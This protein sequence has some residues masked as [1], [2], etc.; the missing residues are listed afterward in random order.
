MSMEFQVNRALY[1]G[2]LEQGTKAG[3][4][5]VAEQLLTDCD[6]YIKWDLGTMHDSG[7]VESEGNDA[8]VSW[9]TPYAKRQYY[10]GK[11]IQHGKNANPGIMWAHKAESA[12]KADYLR[13][14]IK[15]FAE[16]L[17]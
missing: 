7:R 1:Q 3:T 15:A 9:N 17:K 13:I 8:G 6:E 12:H 11:G 4:K 2:L 10:T 16:G 14:I 5:A